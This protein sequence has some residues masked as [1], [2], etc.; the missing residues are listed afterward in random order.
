MLESPDVWGHFVY[1]EY[2][3]DSKQLN[4]EDVKINT[5]K[6]FLG[7]NRDPKLILFRYLKIVVICYV[8]L[9]SLTTFL[10]SL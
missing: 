6:R 7:K 3:D 2:F 1:L 9:F 10:S 5:Y 4:N 8:C